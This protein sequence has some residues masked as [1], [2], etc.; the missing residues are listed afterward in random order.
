MEAAAAQAR[1]SLAGVT[2]RTTRCRCRTTRSR[3]RM[4]ILDC[5]P[6]EDYHEC[7]VHGAYHYDIAWRGK[8][9]NQGPRELYWDKAPIESN[10]M[11]EARQRPR[12]RRT[13]RLGLAFVEKLARRCRPRAV[14]DVV[15]VPPPRA[16]REPLRLYALHATSRM[17]LVTARG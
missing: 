7:R 17:S 3:T 15:H 12:R 11:I 4:M 16:P 1:A 13:Q 8:A 14:H 10:K 9:T 2:T 5:R 6:F